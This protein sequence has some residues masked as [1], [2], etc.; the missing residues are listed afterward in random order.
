MEIVFNLPNPDRSL[1]KSD[2]FDST[3]KTENTHKICID[4]LKSSIHWKGSKPGGEHTG[5]VRFSSGYIKFEENNVTGGSFVADM[6]TIEDEELRMKEM[7]EM[8]ENHLKSADFFDVKNYPT[9]TFEIHTVKLLPDDP[10]FVME[11]TGALTIKDIPQ[12]VTFKVK[13]LSQINPVSFTTNEVVL[14]RTIW[15]I[16][17][18]SKSIFKSITDKIIHDEFEISAT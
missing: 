17:Y 13:Q 14:N 11:M 3:S 1:S 15:K 7:K 18:N 16:N 9:A 12:P 6:T 10:V 4:P 2:Q 8:L 5:I